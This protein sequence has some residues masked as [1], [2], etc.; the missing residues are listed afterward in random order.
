MIAI[1]F[2]FIFSLKIEEHLV[3]KFKVFPTSICLDLKDFLSFLLTI[4][5]LDFLLKASEMKLFPSNFFPLIAKKYH[6]FLL[7]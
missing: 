6:F 1:I 2:A 5:K 4:A 3:R 7:F